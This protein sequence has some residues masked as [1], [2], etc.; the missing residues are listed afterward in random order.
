M[1]KFSPARGYT[2]QDWD[3]VSDNPMRPMRTRAG[4]FPSPS[5]LME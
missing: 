3:E 1:T 5:E 2:E 4:K